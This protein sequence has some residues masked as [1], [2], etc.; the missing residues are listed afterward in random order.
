MN[1]IFSIANENGIVLFYTDTDSLHMLKSQLPLLEKK[2]LEF[3]GRKLC[4]DNELEHFHVDFKLGKHKADKIV[5]MQSVFVAKKMYLDMLYAKVDDAGEV[6]EKGVHKKCKGISELS[7]DHR[8]YTHHNGDYVNL[9]LTLALPQLMRG[10]MEFDMTAD[11]VLPI[12][13]NKLLQ[14]VCTNDMS[15]RFKIL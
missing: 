12:F 8:C 10:D 6:Y 9:Y 14:S 3:K 4:D 1:E 7:V 5:S 2:F 15:R 13:T 11:G